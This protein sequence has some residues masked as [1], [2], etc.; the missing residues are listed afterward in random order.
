MRVGVSVVRELYGGLTV[1]AGR[2]EA[3]VV[4]LGFWGLL[5]TAAAVGWWSWVAKTLPEN[6]EAGSGLMVAIIQIAIALDSTLG[7]LLFDQQ[8]YVST[9]WTSAGVLSI[10]A[11]LALMT[12]RFHV[13]KARKAPRGKELPRSGIPDLASPPQR[14]AACGGLPGKQ[15]AITSYR[16]R[17]S[18]RPANTSPTSGTATSPT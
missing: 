10:A 8:G 6:A 11:F 3:V 13:S 12:R 4:L 9:F 16:F 15:T 17:P 5:S 14:A 1:V 18:R 2:T 7:G